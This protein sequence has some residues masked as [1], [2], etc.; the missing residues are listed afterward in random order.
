M[1]SRRKRSGY[2]KSPDSENPYWVTF[3]DLMAGLLVIFIL[4]LVTMMIQQKK[5][6][7]ELSDQKQ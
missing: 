5:K 7:Q 3:S 2:G 4:A 1:I 6:T